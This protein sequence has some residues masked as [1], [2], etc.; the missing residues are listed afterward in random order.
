[1]AV[2]APDLTEKLAE[3]AERYRVPGVSVGLYHGG[4]EQYAFTGVTSVENPLPVDA[5]TL[6]QIGSTTKTF[7]ATAIMRLVERGR[8]D[9]DAPVRAYVPEL[10]LKDDSVAERVTVLH[11]LNHTAGWTGD[12]FDDTGDGDDAL[13]RYVERMAELEQV[14][15]LGT[16]GSYNNASLCLAGRVIEKVTGRTYEAALKELV[17]GPLGLE[18]SYLFPA[19]V[20]TLRFAV[21]HRDRDDGPPEVARPWRLPRNANAAGGVVA[22]AGDQVRYA[23]F[24]LGDGAG[25]LSRETLELMRRQTFDLHGSAIGDAVGLTWLLERVGDV[26]TVGHGGSTNGQQSAFVMVPERDFAIAVLTNSDAG[27]GLERSLVSWALETCLG[28]VEERPEPLRL[29][30]EQLAEYAGRYRAA[31]SVI[32]IAVEGDRLIATSKITEEARE[33]LREVLGDPPDPPPVAIAVLPDDAY[34]VMG[35]KAEGMRGAFVR[36]GGAVRGVNMGGRVALRT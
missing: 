18:H 4:A 29:T 15:P 16:I 11:L 13:A 23:R 6:F 35:G 30:P 19:D 1:M 33:R 2:A 10:R 32:T 36:E 9:L 5:G 20:M 28:V 25:V 8:V 3:L 14:S 7:T 26:T 34:V 22:T 31:N 17:L 21:G 12:F 27:H 24:H